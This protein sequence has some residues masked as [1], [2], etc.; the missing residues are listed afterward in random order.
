MR[1]SSARLV[2]GASLLVIVFSA[3]V[4]I[5]A[6][7]SAAPDLSGTWKLNIAKSTPP[8]TFIL[9]EETI[10]ISCSGQKIEFRFGRWTSDTYI[11]DGKER[12]RQGVPASTFGEKAEWQ[13][14]VL[15][16]E[17]IWYP[18]FPDHSDFKLRPDDNKTY[19]RLSD[20]RRTLLRETEDPKRVLL[21]ERIGKPL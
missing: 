10:V 5:S 11:A 15:V 16:T 14:A 17:R 3:G 2:L 1:W 8:K 4:T 18:T 9:K 19:W 21:Y 13:G 12:P 7:N 20:E 6:Q